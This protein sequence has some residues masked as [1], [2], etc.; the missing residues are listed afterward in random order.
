MLPE[1]KKYPSGIFPTRR[2]FP[3][4]MIIE[5]AAQVS[6]FLFYESK[7]PSRKLDFYL[8]VVKDARFYR[9]VV[10]GEVR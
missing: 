9:P 8:G 7:N 5:A 10:P 2:F 6:T 4:S 3:S 1:T